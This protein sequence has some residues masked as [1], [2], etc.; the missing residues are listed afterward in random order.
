MSIEEGLRAR[1]DFLR[2][3]TKKDSEYLQQTHGRLCPGH[4]TIE[5][6]KTLLLTKR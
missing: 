4:L 3:V 2:M 1:L 6:F 5:I